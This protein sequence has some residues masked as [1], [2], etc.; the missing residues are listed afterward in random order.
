MS[1]IADPD[2]TAHEP[3]HLDLCCLQKPIIIDRGSERTHISKN[4]TGVKCKAMIINTLSLLI[5]VGHVALCKYVKQKSI[6]RH[7]LKNSSLQNRI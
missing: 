3:S 5:I 2:E 1:N 7:L 4:N 6:P